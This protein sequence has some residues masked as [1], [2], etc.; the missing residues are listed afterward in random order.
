MVTGT[1]KRIESL[2]AS[3]IAKNYRRVAEVGVGENVACA[4]L[5]ARAGLD[6]F[7]TDIRPGPP[8]GGIP[9][10]RDDV[11]SPSVSLYRDRDLIYSIRPHEEMVPPL[12]ALARE[13]D[14]DLLVYHLGFEGY[15]R[16]GELVDCGV[17][18]HRY[19]RCQ[20]PSKRVL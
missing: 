5:L 14:C 9:F 12:I 16:G 13:V 20:N 7:C 4:R 2:I 8:D 3:H 1:Y 19:H 15:G 17:I 6:V 11:F 10:F 18:L